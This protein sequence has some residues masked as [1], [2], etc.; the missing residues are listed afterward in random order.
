MYCLE[1]EEEM[2]H[3]GL[4]CIKEEE[5]PS[6]PVSRSLFHD[7]FSSNQEKTSM[8]MTSSYKFNIFT[9]SDNSITP[10]PDCPS[11]SNNYDQFI[12][13]EEPTK[14][15]I[16][17]DNAISKVENKFSVFCDNEDEKLELLLKSKP[18]CSTHK[19]PTYNTP[20][21]LDHNNV[22]HC[23]YKESE[24]KETASI[25]KGTQSNNITNLDTSNF[26]KLKTESQLNYTDFNR[27]I[28]K[29]FL[30]DSQPSSSK[31]DIEPVQAINKPTLKKS[32][33]SIFTDESSSFPQSNKTTSKLHSVIEPTASI[34]SSSKTNDITAPK[35]V[36]KKS[37]KSASKFKIFSDDL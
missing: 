8:P 13:D 5:E 27:E 31:C 25:L 12:D 16:I 34:K 28:S 35:I 18:P 22:S 33:F 17:N 26:T 7:K 24:S 1:Q 2:Q 6:E 32:N 29:G 11:V 37:T 3:L 4:D 9:E 30:V 10:L 36:K 15:T 19:M 14:F 20:N 21:N 23:I